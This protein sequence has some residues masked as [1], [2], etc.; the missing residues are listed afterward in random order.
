MAQNLF[1]MLVDDIKKYPNDFCLPDILDDN[2]CTIA[3]TSG[4]LHI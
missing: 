3:F 1:G 2:V 4:T